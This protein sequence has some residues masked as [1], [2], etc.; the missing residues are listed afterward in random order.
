MKLRISITTLESFRLFQTSEWF[1]EEKFLDQITGEFVANPAMNFGTAYHR[2]IEKGFEIENGLTTGFDPQY[3]NET[4]IDFL[5]A[6]FEITQPAIDFRNKHPLISNEMKVVKN[7]T[8]MGHE[9]QL[10]AKCDG[11]EGYIIHEH[12]TTTNSDFDKYYSSY[13]WRFYCYIFGL[14]IVQYNIFELIGSSY[15]MSKAKS[16]QEFYK[17]I[18]AVKLEEIQMN[19]YPELVSDCYSLLTNFIHYIEMKNLAQYFPHKLTKIN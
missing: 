12:K 2:L 10:V 16:D 3:P 18:Q 14:D 7:I 13:Q 19:N 6:K 5:N 1:S 8:M 4:K 9:I 11:L 15:K 17:E